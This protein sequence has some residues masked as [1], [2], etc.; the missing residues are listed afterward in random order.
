MRHNRSLIVSKSSLSHS[1]LDPLSPQIRLSL[2]VAMASR[3]SPA[4][5]TPL[6]GAVELPRALAAA[7]HD[8][9]SQFDLST[10]KLKEITDKMLWEYNEGLNKLPTEET[11]DTFWS[12]DA[13]PREKP[14]SR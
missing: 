3:Q 10:D 8:I 1:D 13:S 12:V 6:D 2:V 9:E 14:P 5:L 11:K 7:V 4:Y